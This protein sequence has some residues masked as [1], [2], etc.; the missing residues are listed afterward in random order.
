MPA[1]S[2]QLQTVQKSAPTK[3]EPTPAAPREANL[4][5]TPPA[6][7]YEQKDSLVVV[8]DLP[9]ADEKSV[10]IQVER[11]LL[12]IG[13]TVEREQVADHQ[14]SY[15]EFESGRFERRFTLSDEVDCGKIEATVRDGVLRIVLPK[16]ESAKPRKI[17]VRPA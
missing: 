12:T 11:N 1:E 5:Y 2:K 17:T 15:L 10:D 8:M 7:I 3:T 9:G 6:D 13:T 14:P 16:A 4:L